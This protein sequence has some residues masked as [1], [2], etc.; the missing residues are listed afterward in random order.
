MDPEASG[1][2]RDHGGPAGPRTEV[3]GQRRTALIV[4]DDDDSRYMYGLILEDSGFEVITA[5]SGHEGLRLARDVHPDVILMDV[6]IPKLD[7][8][9]VTTLLKDDPATSAIPVIIITAHAF[10]EDWERADRVR[11]DAFLT[12]PCE[13]PDVLDQVL[14]LVGA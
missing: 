11:C 1:E 8:W 4:E 6:S 13:P 9:S 12:K 7:G 5:T 14:R 3:K 2:V 10:P